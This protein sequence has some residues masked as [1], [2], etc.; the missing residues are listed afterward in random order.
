MTSM[1]KQSGKLGDRLRDLADQAEINKARKKR[2]EDEGWRREEV[3]YL[4]N[5]LGPFAS[6]L[7][8]LPKDMEEAAKEGAREVSYSDGHY[9]QYRCPATDKS[10]IAEVK[11]RKG[12]VLAEIQSYCDKNGLTLLVDTPSHRDDGGEYGEPSTSYWLRVKI[13][14]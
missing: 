12:S 5:E 2:K 8:D 11:K 4:N 1:A 7:K 9:N 14:W 13:S 3:E 6:V 10:T